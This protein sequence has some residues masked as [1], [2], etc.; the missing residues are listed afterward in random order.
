MIPNNG[1]YNSINYSNRFLIPLIIGTGKLVI[2]EAEVEILLFDR[3]HVWTRWWTEEIYIRNF[4]LTQ[5]N[6]FIGKDINFI[7]NKVLSYQRLYE[8]K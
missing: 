1:L 8:F 5:A 7:Y 3:Y 4:G 2:L 6:K